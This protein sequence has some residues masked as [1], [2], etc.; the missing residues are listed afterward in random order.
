MFPHRT[1]IIR[2][3][4]ILTALELSACT[5][6]FPSEPT[7]TP[8]PTFTP[9]PPTATPE[10]LALT[11]NGEGIT[12]AEFD[13]EVARY[14]SVQEALGKTITSMDATKAVIDDLTSQLLLAQGARADG[15][16]LDD[17]ALQARIDS[18]AAQVG[19]VENL[20]K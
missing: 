17:T 14:T 4:L 1:K 10:P 5:S 20:S 16:S 8:A 2:I 12:V 11:V 7:S 19:G 13:A 3:F 15:F 9:A 6:L 18:L